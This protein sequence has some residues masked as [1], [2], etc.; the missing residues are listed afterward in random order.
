MGF[1]G[2]YLYSNDTTC[3]IR[4]NYIAFLRDGHDDEESWEL[5]WAKSKDYIGTDEEAL[6]WY[7]AAETMWQVGRLTPEVKE[8]ALYWIE[9]KGGMEFWDGKKQL[10]WAKTLQNLSDKL[11]RP[12]PKRKKITKPKPL[13]LDPWNLNDVYAY[14][15]HSEETKTNGLYG[16]YVL[17]QK[18]GVGKAVG[19]KTS[20]P[21]MRVH[22]FDCVFDEIPPIEV[23]DTLR[24]LP[25]DTPKRVNISGT[26]PYSPNRVIFKKDPIWINRYIYTYAAREYPQKYLFYLG[27]RQGPADNMENDCC[28]RWY[29]MEDFVPDCM[30][31]WKDL[32]YKTVGEG[33]FD[34][35]PE[36]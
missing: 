29:D 23:I 21:A 9:Q 35:V 28:F 1:R 4:D 8:Q 13:N 15:F 36:E 6:F 18:I 14:Q 34:Y 24:L 7:A 11:N 33:I 16:K 22:I 30:T 25:L 31:L 12:M 26:A 5:L 27:N 10:S 3:D 32:T 20:P 19:N 2:T 17:I